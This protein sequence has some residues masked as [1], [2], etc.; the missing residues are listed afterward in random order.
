MVTLLFVGS[1]GGLACASLPDP[2]WIPG[3]Y[4]DAD[5]D[6]V[7]GLVDLG[8]GQVVSADLTDPGP[9][10]APVVTAV[11]SADQAPASPS[12]D[13]LHARPPPAS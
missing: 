1:L 9:M 3:V 2:S 11:P 12:A 5:F 4:D 10:P 7:V 8:A 6:D 13:A